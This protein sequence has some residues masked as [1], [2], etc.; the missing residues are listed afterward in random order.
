MQGRSVKEEKKKKKEGTK[1]DGVLALFRSPYSILIMVSTAK[2]SGVNECMEAISTPCGRSHM[3][4]ISSWRLIHSD[5]ERCGWSHLPL[6]ANQR[7]LHH[8]GNPRLPHRDAHAG[9]MLMAED[10]PNAVLS[11]HSFISVSLCYL[12]RCNWFDSLWSSNQSHRAV[13][14]VSPRLNCME[15]R[16]EKKDG[17]RKYCRPFV[18]FFSSFHQ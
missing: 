18:F 3:P 2:P 11:L 10:H 4:L 5:C 12:R 15:L 13:I 14:S 7:G 8:I 1:K 17:E 9:K 16:N 6:H